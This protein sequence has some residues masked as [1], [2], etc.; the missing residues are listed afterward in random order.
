MSRLSGLL[1]LLSLAAAVSALAIVRRDI[2]PP[3]FAGPDGYNIAIPSVSKRDVSLQKRDSYVQVFDGSGTGPSDTDASIQGGA[4]L[5]FTR[6]DTYDL[7]ACEAFCDGVTACVF[8]NLFI[9]YNSD[10]TYNPQYKCAAYS[11]VHTAAEKTNFGGQQLLPPPAGPTYVQASVGYALA[12]FEDPPT[13]DGYEFV[14]GPTGGANNAGGYMGSADLDSYDVAAC[15][16]QCNTR[17][18]DATGGAC[19]YFNIWRAV[20][21]GNPTGYTCS[22]YYIPTDASTATN[23][24]QG[25]LLVTL[26]RGYQRISYLP[27]GGF[28]DYNPGG[29]DFAA[30]DDNWIGTS[31]PGGTLDATIFNFQPYAHTGNSV[32]LLGSA[33]G[34][35]ALPGTLT[36]AAPLNLEAGK[37]Y[38]VT[39]FQNSDFS[40]GLET[41]AYIEV[42]W[43]GAIVLT[44]NPGDE[45]WTYYQVQVTAAGNDQL[46]FV[47]GPAPGWSF[48]DDIY[49]WLA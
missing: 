19:Q 45:N 49:V 40:G 11:D 23:Y 34:A 22:M 10:A 41:D 2:V 14:F 13:P 5:T 46:A 18:A 4:Y 6:L 1:S 39:F 7:G 21:N 17:G 42:H 26:S 30:S 28:E 27:D 20:T 36:P 33:I 3:A 32:A 37:A 16:A 9:E 29:F 8:V 47:G 35:D 25:D 38:W 48:L 12:S 44:I 24:G 31:P 15:A 43:N